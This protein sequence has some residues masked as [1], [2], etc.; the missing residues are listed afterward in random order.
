MRGALE[1]RPKSPRSAQHSDSPSATACL[2][3]L[4]TVRSLE[5]LAADLKQGGEARG[6]EMTVFRECLGDTE[7]FHDDERDVIDGTGLTSPTVSR[8]TGVTAGA[9]HV[10]R[11]R[12][13]PRRNDGGRGWRTPSPALRPS[14][15]SPARSRPAARFRP[16]C[17][18]Q[19]DRLGRPEYAILIDRMDRLRHGRRPSVKRFIG[20]TRSLRESDRSPRVIA[21]FETSHFLGVRRLPFHVE[22]ARV[23]DHTT[24]P[25]AGFL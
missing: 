21:R 24:S 17:L 11:R 5:W 15:P 20:P 8:N 16:S 22:P 1:G 12:R 6:L 19:I 25:A 18:R 7:P 23:S 2:N 13:V 10:G 9:R 14:L 4:L 3:R